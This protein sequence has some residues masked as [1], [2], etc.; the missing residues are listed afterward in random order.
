MFEGNDL[1][2][3]VREVRKVNL[4]V[5]MWRMGWRVMWGREVIMIVEV[6]VLVVEE[7]ANLMG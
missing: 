4:E 7:V 1:V 2:V 5:S 3:V 6:I